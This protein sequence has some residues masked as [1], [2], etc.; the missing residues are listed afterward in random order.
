MSPWKIVGWIAVG[1]AGFTIALVVALTG[2]MCCCCGGLGGLVPV[3]SRLATRPAASQPASRP[4]AVKPATRPG[5]R[6][7]ATRP[8]HQARQRRPATRDSGTW[9]PAWWRVPK[10]AN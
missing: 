1:A 4:A 3:V 7:P 10:D 6:G 2:L 5:P 8:A 9:P